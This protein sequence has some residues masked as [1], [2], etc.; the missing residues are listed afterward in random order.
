[1]E[2]TYMM[3]KPEILAARTQAVGEILAMVQ[4]NG[5]RIKNLALKHLDRSTVER[6]YAVHRERPF[7]PDL[8]DY[9]AS[10]P[11]VAV[12]LERDN[13]I[14][15][16]RELVGATN[17]ADAACGTIRSLF[18]TSLSQNAVHASDSVANGKVELDI[19]FG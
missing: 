16:L 3:I 15:K 8:V 2:Q 18:G 10:G 14:V 5:F 9:I 4:K 1:M 19:I 11:V 12:H 17:P 7:F 13:A 6:F